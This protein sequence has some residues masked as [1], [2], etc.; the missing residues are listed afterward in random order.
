MGTFTRYI[1]SSVKLSLETKATAQQSVSSY[2][3]EKMLQKF[4]SFRIWVIKYM[5]NVTLLDEEE[6]K[7]KQSNFFYLSQRLLE[8]IS[9]HTSMCNI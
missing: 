6:R 2:K 1:Q 4:N 5:N 7:K 3:R 9:I 8:Q